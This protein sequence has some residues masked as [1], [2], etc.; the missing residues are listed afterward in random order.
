MT[1]FGDDLTAGLISLA[2]LIAGGIMVLHSAYSVRKVGWL[3]TGLSAIGMGIVYAAPLLFPVQV[4][5]LRWFL[6][7]TLFIFMTNFAILQRNQARNEL[8]KLYQD[9][10]QWR[11]HR[12]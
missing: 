11:S 8:G 6:R 2:C 12:K 4:V 1:L 5:E 7:F 10:K 9:I 3:I